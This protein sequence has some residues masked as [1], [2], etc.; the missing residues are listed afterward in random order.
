VNPLCRGLGLGS[1]LCQLLVSF[2]RDEVQRSSKGP[3]FLSLECEKH[4][5]SFYSRIGWICTNL[6]PSSYLVEKKGKIEFVEYYFMMLPL[7]ENDSWF[8]LSKGL[9]SSSRDLI[10]HGL[11][12]RIR[13]TFPPLTSPKLMI[14]E[15]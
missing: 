10:N 5:V 3:K 11:E 15:V 2:L 1:L 9:A 14:Q 7:D 12:E 13:T 8:I 6:P 4:L